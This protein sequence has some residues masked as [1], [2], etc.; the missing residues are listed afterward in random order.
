MRERARRLLLVFDEAESPLKCA[1]AFGLFAVGAFE[2]FEAR[3]DVPV[4]VG[5]AAIVAV[6]AAASAAAMAMPAAQTSNTI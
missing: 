3:E 1:Q 2:L 6:A 5:C 4:R